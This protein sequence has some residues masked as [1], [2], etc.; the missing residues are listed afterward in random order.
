MKKGN[1]I[2]LLMLLGIVFAFSRIVFNKNFQLYAGYSDEIEFDYENVKLSKVSGKIH[3]DGN[4]GWVDFRDAG[5]CTGSGTYS[6]PYVI[7]DLEIDAAGV[8]SPIWIENSD[9]YFKIEDCIVYNLID[10]IEFDN[11]DSITELTFRKRRITVGEMEKNMVGK[12]DVEKTRRIFAFLT[13]KNSAIFTKM[14]SDDF[15]N[16]SNIAAFFLPR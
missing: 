8:G 11:G 7:E 9:V 2:L 4:S 13:K 16:I 12:N 5:N 3:I 14:Q 6:D 10:P 1:I 15:M